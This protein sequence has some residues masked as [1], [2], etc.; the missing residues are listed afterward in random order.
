MS[1]VPGFPSMGANKMKRLLMRE[2]H[3]AEVPDSGSGSHVWLVAE[4]R[5][6][7]RWA[8]HDSRELAPI[9]VKRIL[10]VQLALHSTRREG[11]CDVPDVIHVMLTDYG[12]FGWGISS[13]QL[14]EL[15]GGR[16]TR[17]ELTK[18]LE[19]LIVFGGGA[20][21]APRLIHLQRHIMLEN[22]DELVIRVA[23]DDSAVE[24][25]RVALGLTSALSLTGQVTAMLNVP[26]RPTGEAL[27]VCALPSDTLGWFGDQ[28]EDQDSMC[29]VTTVENGGEGVIRVQFLGHG[30]PL[31]GTDTHLLTSAGTMGWTPDTKLHEVI[32]AE[33]SG[34]VERGSQLVYC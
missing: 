24:R 11:W 22:G 20:A 25:A 14:P 19:G 1:P 3:Y 9:E 34:R 5:Q 23:Q 18:D 27:F 30:E 7:I 26:R 13:P 10:V 15:I 16:D 2:L 12:Q 32:V 4:G 33:D 6:R 28:M 29:V 17:E 31:A 21:D 8:F